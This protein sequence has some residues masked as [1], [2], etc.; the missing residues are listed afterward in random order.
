MFGGEILLMRMRG[1]LCNIP[2]PL[3][4]PDDSVNPPNLEKYNVAHQIGFDYIQQ[5]EKHWVS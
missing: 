4:L 3:D 2:D 5:E 1:D